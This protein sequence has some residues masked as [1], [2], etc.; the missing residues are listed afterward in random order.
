MT[1]AAT[2]GACLRIAAPVME[3]GVDP[4]S[5]GA[6]FYRAEVAPLLKFLAVSPPR[7]HSPVPGAG[8]GSR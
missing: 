1:L 6:T 8:L 7:M 2:T 5:P 4:A 3:F